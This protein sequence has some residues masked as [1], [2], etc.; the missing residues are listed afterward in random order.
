MDAV[1]F[2]VAAKLLLRGCYVVA[3]V[4]QVGDM[5]LLGV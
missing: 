3:M 4:S 1:V 2:K 5:V